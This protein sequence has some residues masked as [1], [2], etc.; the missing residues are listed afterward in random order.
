MQIVLGGGNPRQTKVLVR[1]NLRWT[2]L[3]KLVLKGKKLLEGYMH[4]HMQK[5]RGNRGL[6]IAPRTNLS[7]HAL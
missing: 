2:T 3:N 6:E 1:Y 5:E 7:A 4:E